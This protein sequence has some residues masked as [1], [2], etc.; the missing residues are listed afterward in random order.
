MNRDR[1]EFSNQLICE[2]YKGA[3]IVALRFAR[4]RN[5]LHRRNLLL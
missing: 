2:V 3:I 5:K 4:N 1:Y